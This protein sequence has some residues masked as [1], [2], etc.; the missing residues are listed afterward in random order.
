MTLGVGTSYTVE[1]SSAGK[2]WKAESPVHSADEFSRLTKVMA[3]LEPEAVEFTV[4]GKNSEPIAMFRGKAVL[5]RLDT[6]M[7]YWRG[8]SSLD[9]TLMGD[10][11]SS[12]P[13]E[14][15]V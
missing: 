11:I 13:I 1:N 14:G 3:S 9:M 12:M 5:E 7:A 10:G 15:R 2:R 6:T 8:V 4:L